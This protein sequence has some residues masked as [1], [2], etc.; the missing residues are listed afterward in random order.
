MGNESCSEGLDRSLGNTEMGYQ[1]QLMLHIGL[2]TVKNAYRKEK[3]HFGQTK[4][5]SNCLERFFID[6]LIYCEVEKNI[7]F[8]NAL[9]S[10]I[11]SRFR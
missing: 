6:V 7:Q 2:Q 10:K 4:A 8:E 1:Q 3:Q 5:T 11:I 9:F